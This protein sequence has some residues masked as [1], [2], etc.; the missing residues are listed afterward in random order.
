MQ[1]RDQ[2]NKYED[3]KPGGRS[4][5]GREDRTTGKDKGAG[6]RKRV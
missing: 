2:E 3:K 5:A 1:M 4:E 6:E